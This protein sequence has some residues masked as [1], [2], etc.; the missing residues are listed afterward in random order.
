MSFIGNAI[1]GLGSAVKTIAGQSDFNADTYGG[2]ATPITSDQA[3]LAA[4]QQQKLLDQMQVQN[5]IG[6]QSNVFNQQQGL[7]DQLSQMAQGQ[8]PN[9]ALTQLNQTTGQNVANQAALM[10]GQRGAGA[11]AGLI[12]RQAAQQGGALQQQAV[13]QAAT[14]RANQQLGAIGALQGQQQMLASLANQ[15]VG[16]EQSLTQN[17]A[18]ALLGQV[19]AQNQIGMQNYYQPQSL[20]AGISQSNA[21]NAS[22]LAGTALQAGGTAA[23]GMAEGGEVNPQMSSAAILK[24][25]TKGPRSKI[26]QLLMAKG[27]QIDMVNGGGVPGTPQVGGSKDSYANDTVQ[28]LLSPGEIV[29]PR[30]VTQSSD[31]SEAAKRF[32]A[33]IKS[34][35]GK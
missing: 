30:S 28:A 32:V 19:N 15:R 27:G 1:G 34:K 20:N 3:S 24:E 5:N 14:M 13:G 7:A 4:I 31:P 16:Q 29:L 6:A 17:N 2:I 9:P 10:A 33:A 8:G 25:N 35:K 18:N 23:A 22:K 26:G 21:A 12:A 11:N